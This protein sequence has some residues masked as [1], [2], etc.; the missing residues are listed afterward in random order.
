[1]SRVVDRWAKN[2]ND[3]FMES[4]QQKVICKSCNSF[5]IVSV[6]RSATHITID[7]LEKEYGIDHKI[8]SGRLRLDGQLGWQCICGN[9][10]LLTTQE[11]RAF[12]NPSAPS[13]QELSEVVKNLIPDQPKFELQEV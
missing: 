2:L 12:V 11:A 6:I 8:V 5:R 7:W 3:S 10:D 13:P 1:M 9:N 4:K